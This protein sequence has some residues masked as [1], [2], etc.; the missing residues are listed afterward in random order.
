M[1]VCDVG[2][3]GDRPG[4][5]SGNPTFCRLSTTRHLLSLKGSGLPTPST[6]RPRQR[7]PRP[8]PP[9]QQLRA[10]SPPCLHQRERFSRRRSDVDRFAPLPS[11][12]SDRTTGAR[13]ASKTPAGPGRVAHL[14]TGGGSI[15]GLRLLQ[16]GE[17][18]PGGGKAL[19]API[20]HFIL[21]SFPRSGFL[22]GLRARAR[23]RRG[24]GERQRECAA[25]EGA[26]LVL[27]V[28]VG[29][30]A[31]ARCSRARRD[32][33]ERSERRVATMQLASGGRSAEGGTHICRASCHVSKVPHGGR[34]AQWPL[35]VS[36]R[37]W[38]SARW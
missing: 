21:A 38:L 1:C 10:R 36:S 29:V 17:S 26:A 18:A 34:A 12:A 22:N 24:E 25:Y 23:E 37:L 14:L 32:A 27:D 15:C 9:Q 13:G 5:G 2:R 19:R 16:R 31:R 3:V 11:S 20:V 33:R 7:P 6:V 35:C 4:Q 30:P 28:V 8:R